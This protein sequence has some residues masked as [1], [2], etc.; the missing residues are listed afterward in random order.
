MNTNALYMGIVYFLFLSVVWLIIFVLIK[1]ANNSI[2][3][4][5]YGIILGL[6]AM[7]SIT[8]VVKPDTNSSNYLF[9]KDTYIYQSV[10]ALF[11]HVMF[12]AYSLYTGLF[13]KGGLIA[14]NGASVSYNTR[15]LGNNAS[16]GNNRR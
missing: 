14:K 9:D 13:A 5:V 6:L 1:S 16:S 8:N 10:G 11:A 12:G 4:I 2:F 3:Y 7:I 15:G